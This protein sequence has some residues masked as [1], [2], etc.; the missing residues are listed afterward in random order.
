MTQARDLTEFPGQAHDRVPPQDLAAEQSVLGAMMMSKDAIANVIELVRGA[1]FYKPA[2]ELIFDCVIDIYGRGDPADAITVAAELTKRG[3]IGRVGGHVYIHDLL[4]SVAIAANAGYYAQIVREKAILRRLVE[5]SIKIAQLG[6][7]GSGDVEDI[8]DLAQQTVYEISDTSRSEDCKVISDLF[9]AAWD[10]MDA[11]ASHGGRLAGVPTGFA[12]LDELT[13]GFHPG[14]MVIVAARPAVGK[15]TLA[16]DFARAAAIQNRLT[17]AVFSLE[18]SSMEIM[19]RLLS[20][21]TGVNL[22]AIRTGQLDEAWDRLS[23]ITGRLSGAPLFIDDSPNLTMMEIRAKARRLKQRH[24]LKLIVIDYIQLM[25]SGKR[26]ESRQVEVSEF[27]RQIKLLAKELNV[28]VVALSQLNRANEARSDK[29]PLL[30]DLRESGSL[31]QD[32]DIVMLLHRDDVYERD[33]SK[34]DGE[35]D[36]IVAKHR[37]GETKSVR[38]LFQGHL[39]CFA[40]NPEDQFAAAGAH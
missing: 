36:L 40:N 20:A 14:Q 26:V 7:S 34:H 22:Q 24:D 5:A 1:D 39:S 11:L 38:L 37:N 35:A 33:A 15:S 18:M 8:V 4:S 13:N 9:Q 12:K 31:E 3:E 21:E 2:H 29:K 32:A 19:M 25:T 6:Y 23:A 28:P 10:E 30:S 17:T 27:S 16:L